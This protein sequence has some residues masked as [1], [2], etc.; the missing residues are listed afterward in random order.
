MGICCM[1]LENTGTYLAIQPQRKRLEWS[2]TVRS[3]GFGIAEPDNQRECAFPGDGTRC[4]FGI[5]SL[6]N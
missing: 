5:Q 3:R 6:E 2:V 4:K 1:T